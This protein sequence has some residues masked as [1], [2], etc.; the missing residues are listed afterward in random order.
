MAEEEGSWAMEGIRAAEAEAEAGGGTALAD[1][2]SNG[3]S[4]QPV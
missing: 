1:G 3:M 2:L 4:R